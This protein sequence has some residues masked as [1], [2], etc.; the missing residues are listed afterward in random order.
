MMSTQAQTVMERDEML[1]HR[2]EGGLWLRSLR[3]RAGLSQRELALAIG[4]DYYSFVS[5]LESGKGRVPVAQVALWA[6]ALRVKRSDFARGLLR[7]YDPITHDMLFGEEEAREGAPP[8][9]ALVAVETKAAMPPA[10]TARPGPPP[11]PETDE[12]LRARVQR[13]EAILLMRGASTG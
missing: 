3:E 9:P 10:Q 5:Q 2:R 12:D 4:A 13:L 6:R 1:R 7:Y 11:A 8:L